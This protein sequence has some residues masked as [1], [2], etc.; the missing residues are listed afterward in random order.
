MNQLGR[1]GSFGLSA[2]M[3]CAIAVEAYQLAFNSAWVGVVLAGLLLLHVIRFGKVMVFRETLIYAGFLGYMLIQLA[4]T[5]DRLLAMNTIL[6]AANFV[7]VLVLGG[8]LAVF[9]DLRAVIAG[10]LCG[11]LAG[12]AGYTML[13]GFPLRYPEGF[14]YNAIA[15]M[16]L[17][18]LILTLLWAALAERKLPALAL[19]AVIMAHIVATTSIKTNLGIVLGAL[20]AGTIHLAQVSKLLWRNAALIMVLGA[21]IAIAVASN[22]AAMAQVSRGAARI[23]LGIEIL[24]ARENLPGYSSFERRANWQREGL[25]GWLQNPVFGHGV[26][27]FRAR[28]G[29]T[30]H[31][32]HVDLMYNSGLIGIVLFYGVFGSLFLRLYRARHDGLREARMIVLASAACFLFMSFSGTIQYILPLAAFFA[33]AIGILKRA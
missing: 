23:S 20:V 16:Y 27:S 21:A 32:S 17:Y 18:G 11:F 8:S 33:F 1:L 7:I 29:I 12:A 3:A 2:A 15:V 26:E 9:H 28:Y 25:K 30:S 14:S 19:A 6:P 4:W 24:Q 5:S 13:S 31:S 10:A 22:D